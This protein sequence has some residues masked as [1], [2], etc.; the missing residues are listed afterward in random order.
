MSKFET[1]DEVREYLSAPRIV[2]LE[3]GKRFGKL[4]LHLLK[5]H[6]VS[7][8]DYRE[9]YGIPYSFGLVGISTLE[10]LQ[11]NFAK[12][13]ESGAINIAETR[14]KA[15]KSKK[16]PQRQAASTKGTA[17]KNL[18][19]MRNQI[20]AATNGQR[21]KL[22]CQYCGEEVE[23]SKEAVVLN[24][25]VTCGKCKIKLAVKRAINYRLIDK[26][27]IAMNA[28]KKEWI[29]RPENKEKA[30]IYGKKWRA[31]NSEKRKEYQQRPDVKMKQRIASLKCYYKK[32]NRE[33]NEKND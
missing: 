23:C 10:K 30:R 17:S 12:T 3:C 7:C 4:H 19:S 31:I 28:Y 8:D 25:R 11:S 13:I 29:N 2:C 6:N 26:K 15:W 21:G 1:L 20:H 16:R 22:S 14:E 9:K 18:K 33:Q 5:K 24:R 32:K 27:R